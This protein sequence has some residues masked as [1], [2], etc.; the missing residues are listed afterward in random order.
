[1]WERR[2][3][4]HTKD[5][6]FLAILRRGVCAQHGAEVVVIHLVL[7]LVDEVPPLLL[8]SLALHLILV[9]RRLEVKVREL[10]VEVF[11]NLVVEL[12]EAQLGARELLEDG[13]IC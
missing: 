9:Y 13:P 5:G 4:C 8:A 3:N 12:G 10:L 2:Q 6:A 11:E 1:M 7:V